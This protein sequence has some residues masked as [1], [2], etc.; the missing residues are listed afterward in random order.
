MKKK[1]LVGLVT[2]LFFAGMV[3]VASATIIES[4]TGLSSPESTITF[5]EFGIG[6]GTSITSQYSSLGVAFSP[7][8]IQNAQMSYFP[9]ID[10]YN[11]G[12]FSS[13]DVFDPFNI[14]FLSAQTEA[15]FAFVTNT[16]TST[17]STY[18]NGAL[19]ETVSFVTNASTPNWYI[20]SG[21]SFDTIKVDVGGFNNA[22]L[23][24][25]IQL[26]S[27]APVPE[28]ATML[29]FGTGLAGLAGLRRRQGKK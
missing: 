10:A 25:N 26:G 15:A 2:G 24:D 21:Y 11:L 19:Q 16:G 8:L 27:A 7:N 18:L 28:P 12:N 4:F 6:S 5:D 23:L 9:N 20:F 13:N 17:F 1:L 29:L 22:M 3:G 14:E